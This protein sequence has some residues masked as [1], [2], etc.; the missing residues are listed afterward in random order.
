MKIKKRLKPTEINNIE[1]IN[2]KDVI[3]KRKRQENVK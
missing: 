2:L 3:I 1:Q